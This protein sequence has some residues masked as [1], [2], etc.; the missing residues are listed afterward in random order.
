MAEPERYVEFFGT[1]TAPKVETAPKPRV[2]REKKKTEAELKQERK[3]SQR[4]IVRVAIVAAVLFAAFALV[5]RS[6]VEL[7]KA[8]ASVINSQSELASAREEYKQLN[9]EL[10]SLVSP[11]RVNEYA[12]EHSMKQLE[13]YQIHYIE[14]EETDRAVIIDGSAAGEVE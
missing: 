12:E 8:K 13:R 5:I 14:K 4:A 3:E 1:S 7:T 6:Q 10:E 2:V 11:D 9:L